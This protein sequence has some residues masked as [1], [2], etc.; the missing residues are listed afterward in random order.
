[1]DTN[2]IGSVTMIIEMTDGSRLTVK[3]DN[4]VTDWRVHTPT[5]R[6]SFDGITIT[7]LP[8]RD[9]TEFGV[10]IKPSPGHPLAINWEKAP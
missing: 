4:P 2:R 7:Q 1:M 3:A 8:L 10:D 6:A 9:A 5:M